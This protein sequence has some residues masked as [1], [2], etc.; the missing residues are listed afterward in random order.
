MYRRFDDVDRR[1]DEIDK[2]FEQWIRDSSSW[3]LKL[4]SCGRSS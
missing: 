3:S 1:F 2:R 4:I